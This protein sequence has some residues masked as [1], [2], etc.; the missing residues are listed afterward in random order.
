MSQMTSVDRIPRRLVSLS[1]L[2]LAA[3]APA[4]VRAA[5]PQPAKAPPAD[6]AAEVARLK[7]EVAEQKQLIM[8][9]VRVEQ[10]H[11]DLLL[12]LIQGRAA[13]GEA[14][15]PGVAPAAPS[16]APASPAAP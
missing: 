8:Q 2:A 12:K 9:L 5:P 14:A 1:L 15:A 13:P 4:T 3:L 10:E 7:A 16:L 11:Y 6:T